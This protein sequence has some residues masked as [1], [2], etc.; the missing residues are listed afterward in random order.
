MYSTVQAAT[1]SKTTNL[2]VNGNFLIDL[3][4]ME[5]CNE[6]VTTCHTLAN[7]VTNVINYDFRPS[8]KKK[9]KNIIAV[10]DSTFFFL[11]S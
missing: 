7:I 11:P 3:M 2:N 9:K 1:M 6:R 8:R 4:S 5:S 10:N